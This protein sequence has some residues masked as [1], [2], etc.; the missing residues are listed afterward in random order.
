M[1]NHSNH[2]TDERI[3]ILYEGLTVIDF[4]KIS[5]TISQILDELQSESIVILI[6]EWSSINVEHQPFLA[7]MIRTMVSEGKISV[8]LGCIEYLTNLSVTKSNGQSI[9]YPIT[10]EIFVDAD[11]DKIHNSFVDIIGATSFLMKILRKHLSIIFPIFEK[12]SDEEMISFCTDLFEQYSSFEEIV[13]ASAG[14]PRDFLLLFKR[15]ISNC[16]KIPIKP[17]QSRYAIH[18]FFQDEKRNNSEI[19]QESLKLFDNIFTKICWP[20]RIYYFFIS[21]NLANNK[22]I[23]E[24]WNHRLIH[25]IHKGQMVLINDKP[26][27]FNIYAID[28]GLFITTGGMNESEKSLKAF[29]EN[30]F[31]L[32]DF[33]DLKDI[34]GS[35][36][37]KTMESSFAKLIIKASYAKMNIKKPNVEQLFKNCVPLVVDSL[38]DE[39]WINPDD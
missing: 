11:L 9:G 20:P 12:S 32:F 1:K 3:Q 16:S 31:S 38:I 15:A 7:E 21:Q 22:L 10:T 36:L 34:A 17:K 13:L 27:T 39:S 18:D 19:S 37:Q 24:L 35:P 23:Q 25:R 28:F 29:K 33:L 4:P 5:K 2:K 8:K 14:V 26:H 6:D 30:T